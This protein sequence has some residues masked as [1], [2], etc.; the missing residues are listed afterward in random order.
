MS[1]C[2]ATVCADVTVSNVASLLTGDCWV[3]QGKQ[4]VLISVLCGSSATVRLRNAN[5]NAQPQVK[6]YCSK[7]TVTNSIGIS[8]QSLHVCQ[9][10]RCSSRSVRVRNTNASLQTQV[11]IVC[12]SFYGNGTWQQQDFSSRCFCAQRWNWRYSLKKTMKTSW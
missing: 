5:A 2:L 12:L 11:N 3:I 9:W 1:L 6:S 4:Y 7:N 10:P 8:R